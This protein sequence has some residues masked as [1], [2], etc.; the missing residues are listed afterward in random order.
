MNEQNY[1]DFENYLAQK[2]TAAEVQIFEN[3][4]KTVADFKNEFEAYRQ[5]T[6][7][8][9]TKFRPETAAF[10]I[11]LKNISKSHFA[12]QEQPKAKVVS[13]YTKYFAVA[14]SLI[15]VFGLYQFLQ[16][17]TPQYADFNT[18]EKAT[19][20]ERGEITVTLKTAQQLFNEKKFQQAIP[21]FETVLKTVNQPEINYFYAI[22]LIET[23][24]FMKAEEVLLK[25]KNGKS[26]Y[27]NRATWYLALM[28]LKQK[29]FVSCKNLLKQIPAD[30]EDY[31]KSQELLQLL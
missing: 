18:H 5:T 17:N 24:N 9:E 3:K 10:Q 2:L 15:L 6:A 21:L 25:L 22:C 1:L 14:A 26:I 16:T 30:A 19:F 29:N 20:V 4:L 31:A 7:F 11:N 28:R 23:D 8:L 27:S 13:M 12:N